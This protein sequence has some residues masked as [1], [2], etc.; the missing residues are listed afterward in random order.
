MSLITRKDIY[1]EKDM[2]CE[3]LKSI[4]KIRKVRAE[5]HYIY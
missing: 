4:L 5:A 2:K 1:E 3:V